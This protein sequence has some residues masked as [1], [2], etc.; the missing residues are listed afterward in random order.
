MYYCPCKIEQARKPY[1]L[2]MPQIT[3]TTPRLQLRYW[4]EADY[5]PFIEMNKDEE[6]REFF[7]SIMTREETEMMIERIQLHFREYDYGLYAVERRDNRRFIGYVGFSHPRFESFFTPCVEI[8]WSLSK[9]N[10]GQGFATEAARACQVYGFET[11]GFKEI[12]SFTSRLNLRSI[13][14]MRK[15][16]MNYECEFEHPMVAEGH[17]LKTHVLYKITV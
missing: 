17:R 16:G 8:G 2:R 6:A 13:N 4:E 15:I 9:E 7:P 10:W 5:I 11:L 1:P 3:L 14:V 12:Y